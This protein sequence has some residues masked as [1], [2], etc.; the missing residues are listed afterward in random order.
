MCRNDRHLDVG[1]DDV[2]HE[3]AQLLNTFAA[4]TISNAQPALTAI[5][6]ILALLLGGVAYLARVY[7]MGSSRSCRC[8]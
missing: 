6:V 1:P 8:S 3:P 5:I 7:H 4:P 2:R